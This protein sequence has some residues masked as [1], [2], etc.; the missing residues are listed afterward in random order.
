MVTNENFRQLVSDGII[1]SR[2]ILADT[3]A[4]AADRAKKVAEKSRPSEEER[5]KG[6]DFENLGKKGK[7]TAKHVAS[8]KTKAEAKESLWDEVE[9]V[10]EYFDEKLPDADEAK[11][12][13]I[14][15]LQ[16]IVKQAQEN[17][18][19]RRSLKA[20]IGLFK[21][22]A[23]KAEE[24]LDEAK[25]KSNIDDED[26]KVQQAGRD[27]KA[28]I[29]KLAN[30]SLDDV[31][32]TAQA[33]AK[34]VRD[35]DKLAKYFEELEN[36]VDRLLFDPGY[37]V[38]QKAYRK[39]SSLYDD[40]QS[41]LKENDQWKQDAAALQKELEALADGIAND[42]ATNRLVQSIENLGDSIATAGKVGF[43]ALSVEGVGLYRDITDVLVPRLIS[44]VKEIP[45]PR[46]E[47]KSEGKLR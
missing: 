23:H 16:K 28:F 36:Y 38:S 3:A 21:K 42:G 41:L 34:D 35:N 13:V 29:E 19:Y 9:G 15:R 40:G 31:I 45:V 6:V 10:R 27:L 25:A 4:E 37:V 17:P 11:E 22:Y 18:E 43:N 14:Q 8:G 26:E 1:L 2:D 12:Q 32:S 33:A 24:A 5:Q 20:L 47:Y 39:A 44:L 46:L 7:E 30:K